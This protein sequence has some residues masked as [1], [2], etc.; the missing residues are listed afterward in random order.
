MQQSINHYP[1]TA[2]NSFADLQE[3][4]RCLPDH[5]RAYLLLNRVFQRSLNEKTAFAGVHFNGPFAKTDYLL[6]E[7]HAS[8]R[9]K[10]S[11]NDA[12]VRL[13]RMGAMSDQEQRSNY[14][15]DFMAVCRFVALIYQV[16]VPVAL[17][18]MFPQERAVRHGVLKADYMRVIVDRWDEHFIY[19][20]ADA[21]DMARRMECSIPN[22]SSGSRTT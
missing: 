18:T 19:A 22:S 3:S 13:R 2:A 5:R 12:R 17:E 11:V 1:E 16:P 4:Y 20:H 14:A 21:E 9:L 8:Q 7:Y 15:Y 6:K 10:R